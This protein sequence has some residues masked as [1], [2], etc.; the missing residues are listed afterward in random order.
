MTMHWL[1]ASSKQQS[2]LVESDSNR[3]LLSFMKESEFGLPCFQRSRV[4]SSDHASCSFLINVYPL[5]HPEPLVTFLHQP[6]TD[7][8][9]NYVSAAQLKRT[10]PFH[11]FPAR[12][13]TIGV[14]E[15][16]GKD[17]LLHRFT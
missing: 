8:V 15:S 12:A 17:L 13:S 1:A 16:G 3:Q 10:G 14:E 5:Q 4:C 9:D 7:D 11:L 6:F 2:K